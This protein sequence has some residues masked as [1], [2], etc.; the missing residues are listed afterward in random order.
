MKAPLKL[1]VLALGLGRWTVRA[2]K[3]QMFRVGGLRRAWS[4]NALSA[5]A[6]GPRY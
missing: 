6:V 2:C 3:H 5:C 4:D 1:S